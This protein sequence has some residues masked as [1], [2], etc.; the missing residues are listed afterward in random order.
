[1]K[2][3]DQIAARLQPYRKRLV[4]VTFVSLFLCPLIHLLLSWAVGKPSSRLLF[5]LVL[6]PMIGFMWSWGLFWIAYWFAPGKGPM[7][8]EVLQ[9]R[10][11]LIALPGRFFRL[12]APAYLLVWFLSPVIFYV[13][14]SVRH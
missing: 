8:L 6:V 13:L 14:V 3:C 9:K 5:L 12:V 10:H 7:S 1:V 2:W 11:W 4:V